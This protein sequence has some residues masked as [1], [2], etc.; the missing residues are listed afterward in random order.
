[1]VRSGRIEKALFEDVLFGSANL[2]ST[3]FYGSRICNCRF[4]DANLRS[5]L[6]GYEGSRFSECLFE[7]V[8]FQMARG[9][10]SEWDDCV[11][12][13]CDF[14][15]FDFGAASFVNCT[16]KGEVRGAWFRGGFALESDQ[17]KFGK[18][19]KNAME[20]VDF[21][22]AELRDVTFSNCCPLEKVKLPVDGDHLFLGSWPSS[23][24]LLT[25]ESR[26]L[27]QETRNEVSIFVDSYSHHASSQ[28]QYIINVRDVREQYSNDSAAMIVNFLNGQT[29][30]AL[31]RARNE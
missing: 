18:P 22:N 11:F 2:S 28:S 16:F 13:D 4:V 23:L 31:E 5:T 25:V 21:S 1:M 10:R 27:P 7:R 12:V 30:N 3:A 9:I 6:L 29:Q 20:G 17:K 26:G 24:D 8:S 14:D 19:R 15:G